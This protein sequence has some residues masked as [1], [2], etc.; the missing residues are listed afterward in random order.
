MKAQYLLFSLLVVLIFASCKPL[1]IRNGK[2]EIENEKMRLEGFKTDLASIDT[3]TM[4]SVYNAYMSKIDSLRKYYDDSREGNTWEI[5]TQFGNIKKPLKSMLT[6]YPGF[7]YGAVYSIS[8]LENLEYDLKKKLI[9]EMQF[10]RFLIEERAAN[11]KMIERF[12]FLKTESA[13]QMDQYKLLSGSVDSLIIV[14]Q[15]RYHK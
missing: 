11:V 8:Q 1:Y 3:T 2:V 4:R 13:A 7:V 15:A 10:Q 14:F 9:T 12:S 5:M 6:E